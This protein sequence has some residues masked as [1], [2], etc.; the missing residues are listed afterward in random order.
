MRPPEKGSGLRSGGGGP[1]RLEYS[2]ELGT[3][4]GTAGQWWA[5]QVAALGGWVRASF[6]SIGAEAGRRAPE[7]GD[8]GH[9]CTG[10]RPAAGRRDAS[11]SSAEPVI[12]PAIG[13]PTCSRVSA[14]PRAV[15]KG[16]KTAPDLAA[17][18]GNPA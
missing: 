3:G 5:G 6:A 11:R 17:V 15:R 10:L 8:E 1:T 9:H 13:V 18:A 16:A 12:M 14:G 4:F 7:G 2:G